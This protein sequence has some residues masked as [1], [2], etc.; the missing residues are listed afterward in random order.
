MTSSSATSTMP[1]RGSRRT[2]SS[3]VQ[4]T[5]TDLASCAL[6][7]PSVRMREKYFERREIK[8]AIA[9]AEAG[10]VAV[11]RNFDS[12]HGSPIRGVTREK[13]FLHV[14]RLRPPLAEWGRLP[15][16]RP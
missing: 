3:L 8:E 16:P 7:G 11:H 14:I 2:I 13:P 12:Y 6:S 4:S 10:G 1:R 9:F 15:G 5:R